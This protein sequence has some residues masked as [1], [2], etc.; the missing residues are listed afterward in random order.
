MRVNKRGRIAFDLSDDEYERLLAGAHLHGVP[1]NTLARALF[2][3]ALPM[4]ASKGF[5]VAALK[6]QYGEGMELSAGAD[7]DGNGHGRPAAKPK[8]G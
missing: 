1:A 7:G 3:W 6:Q 4:F 2:R 8:A 5:S